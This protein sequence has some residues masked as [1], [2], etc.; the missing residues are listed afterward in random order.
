MSQVETDIHKAKV[1]L[2]QVDR[3]LRGVGVDKKTE[4][5]SKKLEQKIAQKETELKSKELQLGIVKG[6]EGGR[7][8]DD[9]INRLETAQKNTDADVERIE[10]DIRDLEDRLTKEHTEETSGT[11]KI[12]AELDRLK[13]QRELYKNKKRQAEGGLEVAQQEL[14]GIEKQEGIELRAEEREEEKKEREERLKQVRD[15]RDR[16]GKELQKRLERGRELETET[17]SRLEKRTEES[18]KQFAKSELDSKKEK[19][20]KLK[21]RRRATK[22]IEKLT[23]KAHADEVTPEQERIWQLEGKEQKI[24]L[25]PEEEREEAK[26]KEQQK[27]EKK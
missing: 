17:E 18:R 13:G 24:G 10:Q 27:E 9:D 5:E 1:L 23:K 12:K 19:E 16:A 14:S 26:L 15:L 6:G 4:F 25:T 7:S 3:V 20:L 22:R 8:S 2:E 21:R 11:A